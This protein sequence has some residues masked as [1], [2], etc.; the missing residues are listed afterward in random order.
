MKTGKT[1]Q[2]RLESD[3]Q[4][5]MARLECGGILLKLPANERPGL[6]P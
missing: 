3:A 5:L 6:T 1:L 2:N 4:W